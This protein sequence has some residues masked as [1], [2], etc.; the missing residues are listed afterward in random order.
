M[1]TVKIPAPIWLKHLYSQNNVSDM[2]KPNK[3]RLPQI[4][5]FDCCDYITSDEL[6]TAVN[7]YIKDLY[8]ETG[9]VATLE[10]TKT[11]IVVKCTIL[12]ESKCQ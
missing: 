3:I 11:Y 7:N 10:Y 8:Q 12:V 5:I 4:K 2:N 1:K 9:N 6:E